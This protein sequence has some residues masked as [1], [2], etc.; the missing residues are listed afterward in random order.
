M[1][2]IYIYFRPQLIE[3][4][5]KSTYM[6]LISFIKNLGA[7]SINKDV[8]SETSDM[9][10][11]LDKRKAVMLTEIIGSL[12]LDVENLSIDFANDVATVYGQ[13]SST[14]N[15]EKIILALGNVAGVAGVD[16]RLSV[17][18]PAPE[19][20]MYEVQK[21]DSLSKI[22]KRFYG[23]PMKYKELFAANQPMLEDPNKIY[24]GQVLRIPKM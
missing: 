3:F 14:E 15:K 13:V 5:S 9:S 4:Y 11:V 22:A 10:E 20:E 12:N 16:D 17:V 2:Q 18:N 23:D 6:G 8:K 1:P 7:K 19:A 24:P 21:G